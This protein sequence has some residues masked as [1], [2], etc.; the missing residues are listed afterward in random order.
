MKGGYEIMRLGDALS[1]IF[2]ILGVS[3]T[4]VA[5]RMMV[6]ENVLHNRLKTNMSVGKLL[7]ILAVCNCNLAIFSPDCDGS[8]VITGVGKKGKGMYS[9]GKVIE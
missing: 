2:Q 7:E 9:G 3:Q 1:H 6:S 5:Q 8:V 4:A